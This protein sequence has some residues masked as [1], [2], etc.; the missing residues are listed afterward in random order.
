VYVDLASRGAIA[1]PDFSGLVPRWRLLQVAGSSIAN[2]VAKYLNAC[3][4]HREPENVVSIT[5][6]PPLDLSGENGV[7]L[8]DV[9][10]QPKS[11][12]FATNTKAV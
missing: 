10:L 4:E 5:I 3:A 6:R 2:R 11:S 1:I 7:P 12:N 8:L 9:H